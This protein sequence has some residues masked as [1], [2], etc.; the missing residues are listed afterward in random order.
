MAFEITYRQ[1]IYMFHE[2]FQAHAVMSRE[3]Q[4]CGILMAYVNQLRAVKDG[5]RKATVIE[6]SKDMWIDV[7]TVE[8]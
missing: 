6:A 5:V 8:G 2:R 1:R 7:L 3:F 4:A